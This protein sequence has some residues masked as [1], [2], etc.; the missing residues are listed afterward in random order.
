MCFSQLKVSLKPTAINRFKKVDFASR[1]K[2]RTDCRERL[3]FIEDYFTQSYDKFI[4]GLFN[5]A[6]QP[7]VFNVANLLSC[8]QSRV[9]SCLLSEFNLNFG[10]FEFK[11]S[12]QECEVK[13][14]NLINQSFSILSNIPTVG[15][16]S[17][18]QQGKFQYNF[19]DSFKK[20]EETLKMVDACLVD[21]IMPLLAIMFLVQSFMHLL[22]DKGNLVAEE[23]KGLLDNNVLEPLEAE[24]TQLVRD[25]LLL[26]NLPK[27]MV[28]G[29]F[30]VDMSEIIK[31]MI[32]S[33]DDTIKN[34]FNPPIYDK[35]DNLISTNKKK[36]N[37]L[38]EKLIAPAPE[39]DQ[40]IEMKRFLEGEELA[41]D[42]EQIAKD[43]K[44]CRK[45]N[46][47][48]ESVRLTSQLITNDYLESLSWVNELNHH[49]DASTGRIRKALPQFREELLRLHD[50]LVSE[51]NQ[52]KNQMKEFEFY[53]DDKEAE[54]YYSKAKEL[55]NSLDSFI[56]R[57]S[58]LNTKQEILGIKKTNFDAVVIQEKASFVRYLDLWNFIANEWNVEHNLWK[59]EP[60]YKLDKNDMAR[61]IGNG[62]VLLRRL[63]ESF[64]DNEVIY[65]LIR[66]KQE[67]VNKF[68]SVLD[69]VKILKDPS[70]K[71][72]HWDELF[73][74]IKE[75]DKNDTLGLR[76]GRPDLTKITLG[77]LM[78]AHVMS[79]T[80]VLKMIQIVSIL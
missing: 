15:L 38:R 48:E 34:M 46:K 68:N 13:L 4:H 73:H 26:Q 55:V 58:D 17:L 74:H 2:I 79:H 9:T 32:Q 59:K 5:K 49:K 53:N 23:L 72:R 11:P 45:L 60:F 28:I 67:E 6:T 62:L 19:E 50:R 16:K 57:A 10:Y 7:P 3:F 42:I 31:Q 80:H 8:E 63:Q 51:L 40:Y 20:I 24:T 33:V 39:I 78:L 75:A 54:N 52:T 27:V 76:E 41:Q 47:F 14:K 18:M 66:N 56:T 71:D 29:I 30:R 22:L 65:K 35:F 21:M 64:R 1:V 36:F 12:I 43:I 77:Q 44:L 37:V 61:V 70:F 69:V 25:R